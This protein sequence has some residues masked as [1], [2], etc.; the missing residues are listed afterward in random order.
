MW[1][2][3]EGHTDIVTQLLLS[4]AEVNAQSIVRYTF[5]RSAVFLLSVVVVGKLRLLCM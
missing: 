1:A 4:H 2:S 5:N 3:L